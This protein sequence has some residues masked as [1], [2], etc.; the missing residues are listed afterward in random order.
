MPGGSLEKDIAWL[1]DMNDMSIL[2]EDADDA[3]SDMFCSPSTIP[4]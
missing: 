3:G 4:M 2:F 1:S